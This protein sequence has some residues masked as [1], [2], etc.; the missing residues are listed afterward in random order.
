MLEKKSSNAENL[1]ELFSLQE[2]ESEE[3]V[4]KPKSPVNSTV[5]WLYF[6]HHHQFSLHL[7]RLCCI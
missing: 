4:F 7:N 3:N 1:L 6:K 5:N 2:K